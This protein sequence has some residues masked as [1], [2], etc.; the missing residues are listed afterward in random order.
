VREKGNGD[1]GGGDVHYIYLYYLPWSVFFRTPHFL[2]RILPF[3]YLV[4][5]FYYYYYLEGQGMG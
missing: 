4:R 2:I 1:G 5:V 3:L